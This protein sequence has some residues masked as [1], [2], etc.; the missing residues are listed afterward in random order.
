MGTCILDPRVATSD[1]R[2]V[3]CNLST[4]AAAITPTPAVSGDAA[5]DC[6]DHYTTTAVSG[7]YYINPGQQGKFRVYCDFD[8]PG[9]PWTVFQRRQN[10][11][12]N[13]YRTYEQYADG[14]GSLADEFWLG[15]VK[16][17]V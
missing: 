4:A 6:D 5:V 15:L 17:I 16:L 13:F 12:T 1:S 2:A 10:G 3:S 14:F 9:G 7:V 11:G 8:T